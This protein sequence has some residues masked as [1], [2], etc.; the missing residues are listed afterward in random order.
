M[1]V[2]VDNLFGFYY[3]QVQ[4]PLSSYLGLLP[5]RNKSGIFFPVGNSSGWYFSE[6]LRFAINNKY[7][8]KFIEGYTFNTQ[9]NVF[10]NY[11]NNIYNIKS[12]SKSDTEKA[13]AKSLLNNLLGW[14]GIRIDRT[15][16]KILPQNKYDTLSRM[17]KI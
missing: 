6:E 1:N 9:S 14:F 17:K 4:A 12:K 2:D 8:V 13:I 10:N 3:V 15:T 7:V 5:V 11:V 16:T